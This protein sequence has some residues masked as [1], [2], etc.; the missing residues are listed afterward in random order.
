MKEYIDAYSIANTVRMV[1][2][3]QST[4]Q[5]ALVETYSDVKRI[6]YLIDQYGY[7]AV[8]AHS[9]ENLVDAV[10]MLSRNGWKVACT[11][12]DGDPGLRDE[13]LVPLRRFPWLSGS[14]DEIAE[15]VLA[16]SN[17]RLCLAVISTSTDDSLNSSPQTA[18]EPNPSQAQPPVANDRALRRQNARRVSL[19]RKRLHEGLD[20]AEQEE[21]DNLQAEMSTHVNALFPLPFEEL[22]RL[23]EYVKDAERRLSGE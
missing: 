23:E 10:K 15:D 4:S 18:S 22:D 3:I 11:Q 13:R 21:L 20:D 19:I 12:V 2:S 8:A 1:G 5:V 9:R 16:L 7:S 6:G 14:L 17:D